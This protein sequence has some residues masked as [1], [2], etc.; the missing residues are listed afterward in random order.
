MFTDVPAQT[1]KMVCWDCGEEISPTDMQCPH[2]HADLQRKTEPKETDRSAAQEQHQPAPETGGQERYPVLKMIST[3]YRVIGALA[4]VIAITA[5]VIE[6][7][8]LSSFGK[9]GTMGGL[10]YGFGI[11]I[12]G[13]LAVISCFAIAEGINVFL[14]IEEN[15]RK[16]AQA[17]K[18]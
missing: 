10:V 12:A 4:G 6:F 2:C 3:V 13:A 1:R 5:A 17:V 9:Y 18:D 8:T 14:D 11:I 7:V 16:A 15:T